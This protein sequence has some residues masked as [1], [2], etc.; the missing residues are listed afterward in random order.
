MVLYIRSLFFVFVS[1]S[2]NILCEE[3]N[4][5]NISDKNIKKLETFNIAVPISTDLFYFFDFFTKGRKTTPHTFSEI[6]ITSDNPNFFL[7]KN[8]TFILF[9]ELYYISGE[10]AFQKI[11]YINMFVFLKQLERFI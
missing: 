1:L 3:H 5:N 8:V 6:C 2:L 9:K 10:A 7:M 4:M 11:I